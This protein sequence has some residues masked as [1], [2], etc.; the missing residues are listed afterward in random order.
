MFEADIKNV[1]DRWMNEQTDKQKRN[2]LGFSLELPMVISVISKLTKFP[3][4]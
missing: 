2:S 1:P 4:L 3:S